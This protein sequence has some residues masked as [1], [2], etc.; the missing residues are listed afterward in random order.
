[1]ENIDLSKLTKAQLIA[2]V[3]EL[4]SYKEVADEEIESLQDELRSAEREIEDLKG[5]QENLEEDIRQLE[6]ELRECGQRN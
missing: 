1:M 4:Q 6:E 2:L 3:E 5:I